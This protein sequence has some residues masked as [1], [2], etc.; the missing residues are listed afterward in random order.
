MGA[1]ASVNKDQSVLNSG[2]SKK[3]CYRSRPK[4][5]QRRPEADARCESSASVDQG[6]PNSP[7]RLPSYQSSAASTQLGSFATSTSSPSLLFEV[8]EDATKSDGD[9]G[10]FVA[11][12]AGGSQDQK[13]SSLENVTLDDPFGSMP[14][15][16]WNRCASTCTANYG[17]AEQTL[18]FL[19]WDDTLFPT[20][21]LLDRMD[22]EQY[23]MSEDP[24]PADVV[25]LL[26]D[27][28]A[29]VYSYLVS[30]TKLSARCVIVTNARR[31]WIDNCCKVFAPE[32]LPMLDETTGC[33]GVVY[34]NEVPLS[35]RRQRSKDFANPVSQSIEDKHM[36]NQ[37]KL[38]KQKQAAMHR[39]AVKFYSQYPGQTWK[40]IFSLGDMHYEHD[41]LQEMTFT[42]KAPAREQIRTKAILVPSQ[43]ALAE[44]T[45]RLRF[46]ATV[47]PAYIKFDGDID[48]DLKTSREPYKTV[49]KALG[50]PE[51][52]ELDFPSFAWGHGPTP[53]SAEIQDALL[54]LEKELNDAML[55][56]NHFSVLRN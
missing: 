39:E 19:D 15:V 50:L 43:P 40:N 56:S 2:H 34:A 21:D 36:A 41:A 45:L 31:P 12:L 3:Q 55:M 32:L 35:K 37:E 16:D 10:D 25:E 29:A 38:T 42:R 46:G 11:P 7:S 48:V 1:T 28:R 27:W 6:C 30:A 23:M 22:C 54:V 20:T 17:E 49:M 33:V 53:S 9:D 44:L 18:I 4:W 14:H 26:A 24:L 47:L 13:W 8:N 52:A 51:L 5:L